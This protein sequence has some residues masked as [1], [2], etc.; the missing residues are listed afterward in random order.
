MTSNINTMAAA[1]EQMSMNVASISSAS[2]QISVNVATISSAAD[3]TSGNVGSV[4][5]AIQ[6]TSRSF[7]QIAEETRQGAQTTAKA[8]EL[9]ANAT[10]TM[11][12]LDRSAVDINKVTEMIKLIAMQTNLLALNATIDEV[13]RAVVDDARSNEA[14]L[15][16]LIEVARERLVEQWPGACG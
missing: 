14:A 11:N 2:E 3:H 10:A 13:L 7:E 8:A 15:H 6:D 1:A 5:E 9:A 4:V 12:T 16:H